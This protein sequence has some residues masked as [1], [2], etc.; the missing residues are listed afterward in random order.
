LVL[1]GSLGSPEVPHAQPN[2]D[3]PVEHAEAAKNHGDA[4]DGA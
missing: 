3:E 1:E 2:A 4:L